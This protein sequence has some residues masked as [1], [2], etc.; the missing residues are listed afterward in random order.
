MN[1]RH[2]AVKALTPLL[3][4]SSSLKYT[5]KAQLRDCPEQQRPFL[6]ELCYGSM[7]HLTQLDA[8]LEVLSPKKIKAKD[9]DIKATILIGLYQL[10][11]LNT[12]DHAAI[13]ETVDV[14]LLLNKRWATGFVNATLRRFQREQAELE[15]SL[16]SNNSF[17]FN[18]PEWYIEKLKHN[19][20]SQW[21]DILHANDQHPPLTLRVNTKLVSRET[22]METLS[23][24][25]I[26]TY[27]TE[28]SQ[29]G[30]TLSKATDIVSTQVFQDGLIS[31]QDEAPQLAADLI[32]PKPNDLIL[33]ACSAPGGKLLHLLELAQSMDVE[34]QGL[35]LEQHRADRIV[36]NFE[37]LGLD[38]HIHIADATEK[39]WWDGRLYNKILLDTPC[40]ATAVIRRNPD[41]KVMRKSEDIHQLAKLQKQ[42]LTNMWSML[43]E[44]GTLVYATC[45]IFKQEN[46]RLI[47]SFCKEHE[48]AKHIPIDADWGE[49]REYGRQLFP[50]VDKHDGFYYAVLSKS[51]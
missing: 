31:V 14:C 18:H 39:D 22:L 27:K 24:E 8:F 42:I 45:S 5:L 1:V 10:Y 7:R 26:D 34:V 50:V 21:Q 38:C 12:S 29:Y 20:P 37:R 2:L 25:G 28:H 9:Q 11:K 46:E 35:E 47:A 15:S 13:S 48:D 23:E 49:Q 16:A 4:Q 40:S 36:E 41:I 44:G 6:Q 30:I 32:D 19:W 33:D 3:L 51:V 43:A 17:V